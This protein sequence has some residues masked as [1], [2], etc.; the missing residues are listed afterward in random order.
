MQ[1]LWALIL[2][3]APLTPSFW[4]SNSAFQMSVSTMAVW[5]NSCGVG[6][7]A[8]Q[9]ALEDVVERLEVDELRRVI[10]VE[11]LQVA[12]HLALTSATSFSSPRFHRTIA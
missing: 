12:Q 2:W 5:S 9:E 1:P 7:L 8:G 6:V 11:L 10:D 3:M 4:K